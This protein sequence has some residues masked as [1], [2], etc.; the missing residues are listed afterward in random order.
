MEEQVRATETLW[1]SQEEPARQ[2][3]RRLRDALADAEL[4]PASNCL[5]R[6]V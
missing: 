4:S 1:G 3:N 5:C 6:A 2:V